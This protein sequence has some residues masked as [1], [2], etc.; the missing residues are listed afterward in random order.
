M[1]EGIVLNVIVAPDVN[2]PTLKSIIEGIYRS[3]LAVRTVHISDDELSTCLSCQKQF[4]IPSDAIL[5]SVGNWRGLF[6]SEKCR[7]A[8]IK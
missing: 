6:C 2:A 7:K 3:H 1:K 8:G 5:R 4:P